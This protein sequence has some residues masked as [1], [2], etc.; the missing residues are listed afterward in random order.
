MSLDGGGLRGVITVA[1]L[2]RIEALLSTREG[3]DIRLG[4]QFDLIGGTST[5]AIIASALALGRSTNELK[6]FYLE[7]ANHVFKRRLARIPF[8]QAKYNYHA[9]RK[10]IEAVVQDRAL[11][12]A[13]IITG[14]GIVIKRMDTATT[15]IATNNPRAA[16]WERCEH[17]P[18]SQLYRL[19]VLLRASTAAPTF[20]DPETAPLFAGAP[21][22]LMVDGGVTPYNNPALALFMIATQSSHGMR[23]STGLDR[24]TIVSVGTGT[25]RSG[26]ASRKFGLIGSLRL[27]V[28]SLAS[29]I[30][31]AGELALLMMQW[32]GHCPM[33]RWATGF[34]HGTHLTDSIADP[35]FRFL[36]YNVQ[37]EQVWLREHL[38]CKLSVRD[39]D[40]LRQ[41]DDVGV[42]NVLYEIGQQAAAKQVEI[43]H[44]VG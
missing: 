37:L 20:F 42:V 38:D 35:L 15:W 44:L 39:V 1:F 40:R 23:W 12:S 7:R 28:G 18:G 26:T 6:G 41:M 24:L 16:Y 14:L 4:D 11:S 17:G 34:E 30:D 43:E 22:S 8:F 32:L 10:E 9:L 21:A 2:E 3:L 31:D 5:G 29:V 36:R 27:A 25:Y 33:D 19:S 13:D